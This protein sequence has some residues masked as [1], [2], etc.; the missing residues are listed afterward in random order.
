MPSVAEWWKNETFIPLEWSPPPVSPAAR[1][2]WPRRLVAAALVGLVATSGG[3]G[4]LAWQEHGVARREQAV[5]R[6]Q[7]ARLQAL[8]SEITANRQLLSSTTTVTG[9]LQSCIDASNRASSSFFGFLTGAEHKAESICRT[10]EAD[11]QQLQSGS[12]SAR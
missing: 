9:E 1:R 6:L 7:A 3:L 10:A 2:R 4:W 8:D 11:Y 12:G 5:V